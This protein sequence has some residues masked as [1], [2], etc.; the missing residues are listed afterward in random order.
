MFRI[1]F[2]EFHPSHSTLVSGSNQISR[3]EVGRLHNKESFPCQTSLQYELD[4][5]YE[6]CLTNSVGTEIKYFFQT[7]L[8]T[9]DQY[10]TF[11]EQFSKTEQSRYSKRLR[12]NKKKL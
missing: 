3:E 1:S 12:K 7:K 5:F 9:V 11:R 10:F 6:K 8:L 4:L 2:F